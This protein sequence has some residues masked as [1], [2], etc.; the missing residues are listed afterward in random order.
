MICCLCGGISVFLQKHVEVFI[1]LLVCIIH[2]I[3]ISLDNF[4]RYVLQT[5]SVC[6]NGEKRQQGVNEALKGNRSLLF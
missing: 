1:V 4:L 3:S 5:E 6:K 2:R